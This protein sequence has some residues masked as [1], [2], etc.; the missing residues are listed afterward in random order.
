MRNDAE[1]PNLPR[2]IADRGYRAL[3]ASSATT[4]AAA[5]ADRQ[6]SGRI[7]GPGWRD[8]SGSAATATASTLRAPVRRTR[9]IFRAG[10]EAP[11]P[12]C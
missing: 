7:D 10:A 4:A 6:L 11:A 8:L 5:S 9:L 12:S 3:S 2:R 1:D